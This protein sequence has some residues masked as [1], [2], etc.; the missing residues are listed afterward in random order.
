M[1]GQGH[2]AGAAGPGNRADPPRDFVSVKSRQA[3][4]DEGD[5]VGSVQCGAKPGGSVPVYGHDMT[6][7]FEPEPDQRRDI[8]VVVND[9]NT[10]AHAMTSG[11]L[12]CVPAI[13]RK[14]VC[15]NP[16]R[17]APGHSSIKN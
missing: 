15:L 10:V 4:I 17:H 16:V 7:A 5:I 12:T 8:H 3:D 1:G 9:Q 6:V 14:V 11:L 2:E 13:N